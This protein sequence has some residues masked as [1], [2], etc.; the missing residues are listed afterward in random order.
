MPAP[1]D[2]GNTLLRESSEN[3][4]SSGNINIGFKLKA[5][6]SNQN[7]TGTSRLSHHR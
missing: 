5:C 1:P 3:F 7:G 4:H 2:N 6:F